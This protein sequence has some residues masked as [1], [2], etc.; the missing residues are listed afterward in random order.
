[1]DGNDSWIPL[2]TQQTQAMS[3]HFTAFTLKVNV[4][5]HVT[6]KEASATKHVDCGID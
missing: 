2:G 6:G 3:M 4:H 1:M 5:D